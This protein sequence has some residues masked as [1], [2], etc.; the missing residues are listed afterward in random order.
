MRGDWHQ[1]WRK[2]LR[3][4]LDWL[5][6][7]LIDIYD[8][9]AINLL[10]DPWKARDEYIGPVLLRSEKTLDEFLSAKSRK[11][12]STAEK[13]KALHLLELQRHAMLMYTSCG[14]FFDEISGIETTQVI[15]YASRAIQIAERIS[16]KNLEEQ[17]IKRLSTAPS[18]IDE[19]G[20][21]GEVYT[22][23]IQPA[24]LDL[25][26][27][28]AH[29]AVS[30]IFNDY[31]E[32]TDLYC[33]HAKS[34]FSD[35]MVSG[36]LQMHIGRVR[37]KSNI[38]WNQ[39]LASFAV[40]YLGE[41]IINGGVIEHGKMVDFEEMH[42]EIKEA[43]RRSDI[44]EVFNLMDKHFN[45]HEFTLWHLFKDEQREVFNQIMES[46]LERIERNFR[47]IYDD[48]YPLMQAMRE[49]GI[50]LP[51]PMTTAIEY[52]FNNDFKYLLRK[53]IIDYDR[54]ENLIQDFRDWDISPDLNTLEF[55]ASERILQFL[56]SLQENP[57]QVDTI[58]KTE[59][60]LHILQ[61]L[62]LQLDLWESQNV[63]FDI[64]KKQ[65]E[66]MLE[67]AGKDNEEAEEWVEH[68]NRLGEYLNVGIN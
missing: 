20:D 55:V 59:H 66:V 42:S 60:L 30:S 64:G 57:I 49:M 44:S 18:N 32:E 43:F 17:F 22:R 24:K 11:E 41:H 9:Q 37:I 8:K 68:F 45:T 2:P 46:S 4:S 3:Q 51:E 31:P 21:G 38:T 12:L 54:L 39:T 35:N 63:Y 19:I 40:L 23:Y 5:R 36:K 50:P 7:E 28:G 15:Q 52:V 6:E 34:E 16:E 26:R 61:T 27:V 10:K 58:R 33:Y 29:Y 25:L 48:E 67:Q 65:Y 1:K 14:W 53:D 13:E 47:Q 56:K 62:P